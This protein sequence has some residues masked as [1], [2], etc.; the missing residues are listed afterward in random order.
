[1]DFMYLLHIAMVWVPSS[2]VVETTGTLVL[3]AAGKKG[4]AMYPHGNQEFS[5]WLQCSWWPG[6][7]SILGSLIFLYWR[8]GFGTHIDLSVLSQTLGI[9]CQ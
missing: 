8:W 3:V 7:G 4:L 1:M 2:L 5:P 9:S 6:V